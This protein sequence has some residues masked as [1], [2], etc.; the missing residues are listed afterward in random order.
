MISSCF[1]TLLLYILAACDK[2]RLVITRYCYLNNPII[3]YLVYLVIYWCLASGL[4]SAG[5]ADILLFTEM[6]SVSFL[7][8]FSVKRTSLCWVGVG[9]LSPR[10]IFV[11]YLWSMFILQNIFF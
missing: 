11:S 4:P 5:I 6:C 3:H 8:A 2:V 10:C 7:L 9:G 1:Y